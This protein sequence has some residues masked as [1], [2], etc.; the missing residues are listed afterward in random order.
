MPT[1]VRALQGN[2]KGRSSRADA[3]EDRRF[4]KSARRIVQPQ[5][6]SDVPDDAITDILLLSDDESDEEVG[7]KGWQQLRPSEVGR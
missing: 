7:E 4:D 5:R 3:E 6:A 2:R 1:S